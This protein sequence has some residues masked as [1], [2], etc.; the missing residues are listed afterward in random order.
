MA[1]PEKSGLHSFDS[2]VRGIANKENFW[3]SELAGI[4][5]F[6]TSFL[7]DAHPGPENAGR[8]SEFLIKEPFFRDDY[9]AIT[10]FLGLLCKLSSADQGSVGFIDGAVISEFPNHFGVLSETVPLNFYSNARG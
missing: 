5:S 1:F 7:R 10:S 9:E 3:L 6:D 2:Y 8:H 4:E